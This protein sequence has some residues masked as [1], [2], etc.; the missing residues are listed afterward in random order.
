MTAGASFGYWT[1]MAQ[2]PGAVVWKV[3]SVVGGCDAT[4]EGCVVVSPQPESSSDTTQ[5]ISGAATVV[6]RSTSPAQVGG[7]GAHL[8]GAQRRARPEVGV[9]D[10]G[11]DGGAA[12]HGGALLAAHGEA[13]A[14]ST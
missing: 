11:G 6:R 8:L 12:E 4:H 10:D 7:D 1:V 5:A 13:K 3:S 9:I 14:E 2:T